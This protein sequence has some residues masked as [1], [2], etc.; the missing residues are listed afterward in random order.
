MK[1]KVNGNWIDFPLLAGK[2][3]YQSALE[4]G[5]VGTESEFNT[6]LGQTTAHITNLSN[7][8]QTTAT[9]VG[10]YTSGQTDALLVNKVD[11][12]SSITSG[13]YTK[14]S[15]DT[16]GLVTSGQTA[17]QDDII[18]GTNYKQYSNAEQTKLSGI[19]SGAQVNVIETIQLNGV[20]QTVSG[21]TVNL[22]V[23]T[24][25][26]TDASLSGSGTVGSP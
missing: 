17:T 4:G 25:V 10:A 6:A 19:T 12:N 24:S 11:K 1:I 7:P 14:I 8:H 22:N 13:T 20:T 15:F 26:I 23:Q 21:K 5:F 16:K 9:Q 2:S 3:A 18:S